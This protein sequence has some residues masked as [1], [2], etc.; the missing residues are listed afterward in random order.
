MS[1]ENARAYWIECERQL[2]AVAGM[3]S[4]RYVQ[5][6]KAVRALV[7]EL[8]EVTSVAQLA[9]S[10]PQAD[11]LLAKAAAAR[12]FSL[13]ALPGKQVAGAAFAFREREI[14][15]QNQIIE[16]NSRIEAA[17]RSGDEWVLLDETGNIDTGLFDPYRRTEMHLGSGLT[18]VSMVQ[19]DPSSGAPN[20]VVAVV[21]LDPATGELIDAEPGIADW[22]EHTRQEDFRSGRDAIR[23]K[24]DAMPSENA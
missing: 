5:I 8:G 3:D 7:D 19:A 1:M 21:R 16:R 23:E 10:W 12:G 20:Y 6:T 13:S 22:V 14:I 17:R 4:D 2:F 24:I 9:A 18:V 15:E 11:Q